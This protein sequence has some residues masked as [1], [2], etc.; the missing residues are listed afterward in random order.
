MQQLRQRMRAYGCTQAFTV[1]EYK[2]LLRK[3]QELLEAAQ[4]V[5]YEGL[6]AALGHD[7][8]QL[9]NLLAFY[10]FIDDARERK[11]ADA[12]QELQGALDRTSLPALQ[13]AIKAKIEW[14]Q[15]VD[16]HFA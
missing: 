13:A 11:L 1:K 12:A 6:R 15:K 9:C 5:G 8:R 16:R 4:V 14:L 7:T 2:D 3:S 10:Q